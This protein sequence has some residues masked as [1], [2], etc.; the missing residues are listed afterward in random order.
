MTSVE[1]IAL[2][3]AWVLLGRVAVPAAPG[4]HWAEKLLRALPGCRETSV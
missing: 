1:Q 2:E 4:R 3:W